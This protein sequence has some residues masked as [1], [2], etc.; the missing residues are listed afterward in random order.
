MGA[1]Q[2]DRRLLRFANEV[3]GTRKQDGHRPGLCH[4][5]RAGSIAVLQMIGGKSGEICGERRAAEI[6]Q[7]IGMQ[8]DG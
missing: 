4:G 8:L 2:L 7:L 5:R 3:E 1:E 6:R